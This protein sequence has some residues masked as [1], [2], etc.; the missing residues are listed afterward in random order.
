MENVQF[1][2]RCEG[3]GIIRLNKEDLRTLWK[4]VAL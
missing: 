3:N 2:L 4:M 1:E